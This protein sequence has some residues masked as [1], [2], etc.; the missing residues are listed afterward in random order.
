MRPLERTFPPLYPPTARPAR[1]KLPLAAYALAVMRNPLRAMPEA[2]YHQPIVTYDAL[3]MP[4][5]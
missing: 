4:S 2:V 3:K 5:A 1:H